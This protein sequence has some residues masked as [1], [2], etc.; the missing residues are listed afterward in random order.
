MPWLS[1]PFASLIPA[2][3]R[4]PIPP[5]AEKRPP[6]RRN[7]W[8]PSPRNG[9]PPSRRNGG[10]IDAGLGGRLRAEYAR[11]WDHEVLG[12]PQGVLEVIAGALE[13]SEVRR[14]HSGSPP[15]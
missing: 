5:M 8:L 13:S 3:S 7:R 12:N 11:F 1:E 15:S 9:W 14:S 4:P 10:W 6:S 2:A